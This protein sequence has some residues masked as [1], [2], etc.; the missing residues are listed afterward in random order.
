MA[1]AASSIINK[2]TD[3][4]DEDFARIKPVVEMSERLHTSLHRQLIDRGVAPIDA[5]LA[6]VSA[7]HALA[8]VLH[9]NPVAAIEWMRNA[10]DL[11]E[12]NVIQAGQPH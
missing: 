9:G 2:G 10:L 4:T 7:T 8:T 12:R 11:A 5:L 3:M 1:E 6:S